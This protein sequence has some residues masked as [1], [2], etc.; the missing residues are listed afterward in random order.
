MTRQKKLVDL[1]L[2]YSLFLYRIPLS[3]F[4]KMRPFGTLWSSFS[5]GCYGNDDCYNNFSFHFWF[6]FVSFCSCALQQQLVHANTDNNLFFLVLDYFPL[7]K[8]RFTTFNPF[9]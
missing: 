8:D 1:F 2:M 7:V 6:I 4:L 5:N 3:S 9:S